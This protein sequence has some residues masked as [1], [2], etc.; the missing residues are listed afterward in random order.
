MTIRGKLLAV[1]ALLIVVGIAITAVLYT[2]QAKVARSINDVQDAL[3]ELDIYKDMKISM[4]F[5]AIAVR[6]L[7]FNPQDE[8]ARKAIKENIKKFMDGLAVLNERKHELSKEEAELTTNLG[9]FT[10]QGDIEN[11]IQLLEL[12]AYDE[13]K[14]ALIEAE[15][16]GF[17]DT[18]DTL[19]ALI[20]LRLKQIKR[21][22]EELKA[23]IAF[24]N[25]VVVGI[26]IPSVLVVS[27]ALWF[28][29]RGVLGN[30]KSLSSRVEE[31]ANNM[32]FK[33]IQFSKFRNELDRLVDSLEQMVKDIGSAVVSIK[34]VMMRVSK[35]NLKVRVQG[36]YKGDIKELTNYVNSSLSDLQN[37]LREAKEGLDS[38][39][40]SIKVLDKNS[41]RIERENE[42]LNSSIASIMTSVD[43]TSEALRQV[44][45]ETLRARNVSMDME[46]S[47]RTGKDKVD[48][49][50]S[51][52][53]R[54]VDVS[55]EISSITETIIT[56]AEQTNLLALNAAIEAARAGEMGRGFAVVADEVR[57][58]AEISGN[59][60]KEIAE[61]V[62]KAL[63]TVEEGRTAS[64]D[65]VD[66]Y[67]KIEEV[68]KEIAS[69][70]DTIATAM[71][72]QSRA[73]DIIRD[74]MTEITSIS[75]KNTS[76][77]K[78]IV[79]EIKNISQTADQVEEKMG[80]FDV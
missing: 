18:I 55:K 40:K 21:E 38:I 33:D 41:E 73:I 67:R 26:T 12:E 2:M 46:E 39:A 25:N 31:L 77:V 10:Y 48:V 57:R 27:I 58:L 80:R 56:I 64:E 7:I 51:A 66:S 6:N 20:E 32:R 9:F 70:I 13:A 54:I 29:S 79:K 15:K 52:M 4:L 59:A 1:N 34:D 42:N 68:T 36:E 23:D 74:N 61:L 62:E 43:E 45:E 22:Q 72:E 53:G 63:N 11:V 3:E 44:S 65:V 75:E 8:E 47:I 37:A 14:E 24:A 17:T 78:E 19:N 76:S 69:V 49:M 60:A 28:V 30:I 71:E 5:T 16:K 50:H 35:G